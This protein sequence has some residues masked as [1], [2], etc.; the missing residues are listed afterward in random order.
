M[1]NDP[2]LYNIGNWLS[3]G[4]F[5]TIKGTFDPEE[6]L[7]LQHWLDSF[8]TVTMAVTAYNLA[9]SNAAG[10]AQSM[11]AS[12]KPTSLDDLDDSVEGAG[13]KIKTNLGNEIDITPSTN[14][15]TT[16]TNPGLKGT[17]NSS[18]DILDNAGNIKTRRWFGPDG[19]QTRDVDF[20]NHGNSKM[21]PE[22]PHEHGPR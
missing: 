16:T 13:S 17:P 22:W 4:L 20:T 6:P 1:F 3:S 7:S 10:R 8:G 9:K 21:H 19:T 18:V 12:K 2:S 14:H 5:D 11:P 15:S